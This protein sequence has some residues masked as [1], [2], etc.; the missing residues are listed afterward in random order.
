[1]EKATNPFL[2]PQSPEIRNQLGMQMARD[3]EVFAQ[4]RQLKNKA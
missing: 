3:W 1:V 4:L 2:R